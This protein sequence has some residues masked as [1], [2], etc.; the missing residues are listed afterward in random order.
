MRLYPI[1]FALIAALL[2]PV[3]YTLKQFGFREIFF[4]AGVV[5]ERADVVLFGNSVNRHASVCDRNQKSIGALLAEG[6]GRPV[7]EL[8]KGGQVFSD[9]ADMAPFVA[10]YSDASTII[11]PLA[12]QELALKPVTPNSRIARA[13]V[14][15]LAAFSMPKTFFHLDGF[16]ELEEEFIF[17][18]RP[19][20]NWKTINDIF[21]AKE[22]MLMGC[23]EITG[24]DHDFVHFMHWLNYGRLPV[25][26]EQTRIKEIVETF[27]AR[28]KR[29]VMVIL[30]VNVDFVQRLDNG[31]IY[32]HLRDQIATVSDFLA[33]EGIEYVD[34]SHAVREE[35]FV[36][37]WCACGHMSDAGRLQVAATL[38][39]I[40]QR[41]PARS[42]PVVVENTAR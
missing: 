24:H 6:S 19:Y 11:V 34:L 31:A 15:A 18:G 23:P 20:G 22:K 36:D 3:V 30:P 9:F 35:V 4:T 37:R 33:R 25:L 38:A 7:L 32:A 2:T 40:V 14:Y 29:V 5:S 28:G 39:E 21:M 26:P 17:R 12:M 27:Q 13:M 41:P 10:A 1:V 16:N 8:A 42:E